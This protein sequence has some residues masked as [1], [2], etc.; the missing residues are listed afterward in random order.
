MDKKVIQ[1][2]FTNICAKDELRPV[3][4]GV[5]FESERCY[6]TDG[7]VLVIY[8]EG[9]PEL[10]GK[11]VHQDGTVI[12]GR[13]PNVDAVFPSEENYGK[14]LNIDIKQLRD[15]CQWQIRQENANENDRVV[16]NGV[17]YNVRTLMR[18]CNVLLVAGDPHKIKFYNSEP[19]RC[20]VLIGTKLKCI[21]MPMQFEEGD[22][23]TEREGEGFTQTY[24]YENFINDY[25]FNSWRKQEKP[26]TLSW[27]D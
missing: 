18:L 27:L 4:N 5:H 11:T 14:K 23:D 9:K 22:I 25:V 17:G 21:I 13:Y 7:K 1:A 3:M 26:Q 24:S 2:L 10:D 6:A 20:S 15:A 19:N 16:I 8:G 12:E